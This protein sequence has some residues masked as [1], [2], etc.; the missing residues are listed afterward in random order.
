MASSYISLQILPEKGS[1]GIHYFVSKHNCYFE[2]LGYVMG[3]WAVLDL[4]S[5]LF[6]KSQLHR[7][8]FANICNSETLFH[9]I[10][11][12]RILRSLN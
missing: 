11:D 6:I 2:P 9:K 3:G 1:L 10:S 8:H 7:R 5:I 4:A 12:N